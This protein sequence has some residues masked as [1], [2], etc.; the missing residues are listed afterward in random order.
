MLFLAYDVTGPWTFRGRVIPRNQGRVFDAAQARNAT[1]DIVDGQ[2][3][4][5]Y[6]ATDLD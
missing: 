2:W 5:M 3:L 6:R 1:I 4:A